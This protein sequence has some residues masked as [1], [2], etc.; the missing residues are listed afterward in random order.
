MTLKTPLPSVVP[1]GLQPLNAAKTCG[2]CQ[3]LR[4][5]NSAVIDQLLD[6]SGADK[7]TRT[8]FRNAYTGYGSGRCM[9]EGSRRPS[10]DWCKKWEPRVGN[11]MLWPADRTEALAV[12]LNKGMAPK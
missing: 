10:T 2:G 7:A 4:T 1:K 8:D 3:H 5:Y 9:V 6:E 11:A 12:G